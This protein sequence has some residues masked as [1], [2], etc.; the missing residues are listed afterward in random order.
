MLAVFIAFGHPNGKFPLPTKPVA[1]AG[2]NEY[3][4]CGLYGSYA[5]EAISEA[6]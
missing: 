1:P 2:L 4:Y 6:C 3:S 5:G